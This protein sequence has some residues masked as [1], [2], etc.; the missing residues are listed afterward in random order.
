[1]TRSIRILA[2]ASLLAASL[3]GSGLF[4]GRAANGHLDEGRPGDAGY[5]LPDIKGGGQ[6]CRQRGQ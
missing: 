1:M 4:A 3:S 6:H 5:G 2:G